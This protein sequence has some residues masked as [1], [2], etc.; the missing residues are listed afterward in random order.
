MK[1]GKISYKYRL[2]FTLGFTALTHNAMAQVSNGDFESWQQNQP[3]NWTTID[4]G[5]SLSAT[6]DRVKSGQTAAQVTVN[7]GTQSNTDLL[8]QVTV[9]AGQ[10]Y[11]FSTWVYHTQGGVRAR[12]VIDGYHG[13][14][15]PFTLNQWQQISH[16]YTASANATINVGLRFYDVSSF[17]G[18]EVVYIDNFQPT[19]TA[20]PPPSTG[21]QANT[22][23][24]SLTT[25]NYGSETSWTLTNSS[26]TQVASGNSYASNQT[27][28]ESL[29]LSDDSY[30]FTIFDNYGD[31]MCCNYGN[32]SYSLTSPDGTLA[33]GSSFTS[34]QQHTF[35]IGNDNGGGTPTDPAEYYAST[36]GLTGYALKSQL[37]SIISTHQS[38]GY[39]A[40]WQFIDQSE[41]DNYFEQD[42][43]VLDRY[44]EKPNTI[45]SINYVAVTNQCGSYRVEGDCY[46]REHSFPKSWFGGKVEPM[47]SDIHHIFATDGF[48]N[49]K[50][51]NFPFGEVANASYI[52][53]NGSKLGNAS[54]SLNYTGTVFEPIDQF[55]GDFARAYFYMAT[56][57]ESVISSWQNNT[58]YSDAVL[59]GTSNQVFEPWVVTMLLRWHQA[60][61]V[62][63]IERAR[64]QAAHEFQ[65]NRNPF[66]D[67]PEFVQQIW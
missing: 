50:R 33:S 60:D 34:Q 47:N 18:S 19:T 8:Q 41:R 43:S 23:N 7:T 11:T 61:P 1:H 48:V 40:I 30:T 39:S 4:S 17:N 6:S 54:S 52:S 35:A 53:S 58:T 15:D 49:S 45:D 57:Y 20:P 2:A 42:N 44:S 66:V 56:R 64:N 59:N 14:S 55:K 25:D 16:T 63:N 27:Y 62:D 13:Y 5:I 38:Q 65:G 32:G 28:T 36:A 24:L 37:H 12:L 29:C 26:S 51:S 46:N 31:G 9:Q 21:C 22:L 10:S 3:S 67:H